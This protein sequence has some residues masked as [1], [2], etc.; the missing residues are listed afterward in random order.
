MNGLMHKLRRLRGV[1]SGVWT[2]VRAPWTRERA[3]RVWQ[4]ARRLGLRGTLR[5]LRG[6]DASVVYADWVRASEA[7]EARAIREPLQRLLALDDP[8]RVS[9]LMPT[10]NS[11]IPWLRD[12]IESVQGQSY[13]H[14]ELC[15]ADDAS[16]DPEVR[17][18]LERYAAED[19]RI[20]V[21]FRSETG[22]IS[23][24]TNSALAL[25]TGDW[26]AFLD[27]DDRLAPN[28]LAWLMLEARAQPD[29]RLIYSDED[30]VDGAGRRQQPFFKPDWS[31][32]L[33]IS[34][35]YLGHL[36]AI[37]RELVGNGFDP[38]LN[39]AQ[40]YDLWLRCANQ[41]EP[42]QIAHVPRV[43]YHWRA[44]AGST[45]QDAEAKPYADDAGLRAVQRYVEARYPS[46]EG[47]V[48]RGDFP[49]TYRLAFHG[50]HNELASIIIPTRDRVDLV[51][52]CVDSILEKTTGIPFEIV[53]VDNGSVEP[54]SAAYFE[55]VTAEHDAVRVVRDDRPFNWS[56]VNNLGARE[57]RGSILVFLNN[58]TEVI[59]PGWLSSLAGYASLPDV[60]AV[61]GLLLFPDGTIQ[62]SGVVVGMGGWADHVFRGEEPDHLN[63][64]NPF[65]SPVLTRN[66]L[67]VTGACTAVTRARYEALGGFD[68]AFIICGS[69]VEFCLKA[70]KA[71]FYN[72][73]CA[74]ARLVHHESK[75]RSPEIPEIDFR[76]SEIHYEPYRTREIDPFFNPNLSLRHTRATLELRGSA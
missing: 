52:A 17:A 73:L 76:M 18:T 31:P 37:Q 59:A 71:G 53:I 66:V 27:H 48:E 9:V 15:I 26:V 20:R 44:H 34:Q 40:D 8:P 43:L 54:E 65:V 23:R 35:A 19:G 68:E 57:A 49:F 24:A 7:D 69:D 51:R 1:A 67:S 32:Q 55:A 47:T 12:A 16:S 42:A 21:E 13:P 60:G 3:A 72:V 30:Q 11:P 36:V 46:L 41:L 10:Y 6:H 64:A 70:W 75:T 50:Q 39:G 74:E 4:R 2:R 29:A 5:A 63:A 58:D 45:A 25:A 14:W 38:D 33:A 22:H 56:G 62:H 28:A 61:G